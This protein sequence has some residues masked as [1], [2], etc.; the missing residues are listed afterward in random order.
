[1]YYYLSVSVKSRLFIFNFNHLRFGMNCNIDL[2]LNSAPE[3]LLTIISITLL[4]KHL[5]KASY[6]TQSW[7][8]RTLWSCEDIKIAIPLHPGRGLLFSWRLDERQHNA[9]ITLHQQQLCLCWIFQHLP[10]YQDYLWRKSI[11]LY[12]FL[13]LWLKMTGGGGCQRWVQ[14]AGMRKAI[15]MES[16]EQASHPNSQCFCRSFLSWQ[17][18]HPPCPLTCDLVDTQKASVDIFSIAFAERHNGAAF[19][20]NLCF[21]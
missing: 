4:Y 18:A 6:S 17:H 14:L 11:L 19:F 5:I 10:T 8:W 2:I 1:M 15:T 13:L 3:V 16:Y 12:L 20:S 21:F 7:R 9:N